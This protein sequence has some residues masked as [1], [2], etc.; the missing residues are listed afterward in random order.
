[1]RYQLLDC[2]WEI[3]DIDAG[4]RLYE[5]G[6]IPGASFLDLD[7]DLS[8]PPG[9]PGGRHPLPSRED[10]Q[11]AIDLR[12]VERSEALASDCVELGRLCHR[13]GD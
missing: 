13:S 7:R 10:F 3:A 4:R 6:H 2:R 11:E 1:M 9:I 8:A 5:E 12:R